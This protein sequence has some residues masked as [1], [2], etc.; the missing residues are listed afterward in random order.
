MNPGRDGGGMGVDVGGKVTFPFA[1]TGCVGAVRSVGPSS[2]IDDVVLA[3]VVNL[4]SNPS[5]TFSSKLKLVLPEGK[6]GVSPNVE[7]GEEGILGDAAIFAVEALAF[8]L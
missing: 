7:L 6:V 1:S 8:C 2:Y 5:L 4:S 3:C